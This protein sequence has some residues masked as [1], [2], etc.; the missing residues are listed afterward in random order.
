MYLIAIIDLYSRYVLMWSVSNTMDAE[1][2]SDVL[3]QALAAYPAPEIF[4]RAGDPVT[5]SFS[6]LFGLHDL[7]KLSKSVCR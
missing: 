3:R 2:C 1:W 6:I 5:P 4:N 7:A